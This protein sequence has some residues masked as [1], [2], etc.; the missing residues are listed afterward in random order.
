MTI[1]ADVARLIDVLEKTG[2]DHPQEK[3]T[4]YHGFTHIDPV[5]KDMMQIGDVWVC[6][7]G[8][9]WDYDPNEEE[10]KK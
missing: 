9:S 10:E 4:F 8:K 2:C 5:T 1:R 7:C 6:S 3:I